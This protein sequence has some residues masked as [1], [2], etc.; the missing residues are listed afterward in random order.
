MFYNFPGIEKSSHPYGILIKTYRYAHKS[1]R[2]FHVQYNNDIDITNNQNIPESKRSLY[3][4]M[5]RN[6]QYSDIDNY[7]GINILF[8]FNV[9]CIR[10]NSYDNYILW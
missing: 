8:Q 3:L 9:P 1:H 4:D 6:L 7:I 10:D 5:N 2:Q